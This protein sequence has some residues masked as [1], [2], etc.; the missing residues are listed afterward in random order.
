MLNKTDIMG[1]LTR[2]PELRYTQSQTAVCSFCVA[3]D[4]DF[5][6]RDGERPTDFINVTAWRQTAEF[7]SRYFRKGDMIIVFGRLQMRDWTDN[8]GNKRTVAEV[9]AE[10]V[11]FGGAK[12]EEAA[13]DPADGGTHFH[14]IDDGDG[15]LPF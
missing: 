14:D 9:L 10:S 13:G 7:V 11:Y 12:R 5:R 2:D 15:E 8:S 4:R 3:C 6:D 1:R